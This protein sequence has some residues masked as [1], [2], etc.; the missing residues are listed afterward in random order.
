MPYKRH[1]MRCRGSSQER[2]ANNGCFPKIIHTY[3]G[4]YKM[5]NT[6]FSAWSGLFNGSRRS[7]VA[8]N[9]TLMTYAKTEYGTDWQYAYNYMLE[10]KGSAPKMGLAD[11]KVAVK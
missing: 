1:I 4:E 11:I 7:R 10:H 5:A 6:F 2:L 9:N 8:Y 3:N